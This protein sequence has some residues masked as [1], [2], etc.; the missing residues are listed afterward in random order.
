MDWGDVG[1]WL[2][3]GVVFAYLGYVV[4]RALI[5]DAI[6]YY[7]KR[8]MDFMDAFDKHAGENGG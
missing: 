3:I 5:H 6:D 1:R 7:H 4:F 2:L 8:Y